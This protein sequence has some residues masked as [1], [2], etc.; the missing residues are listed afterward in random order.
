MPQGSNPGA[1]IQAAQ[2]LKTQ[3]VVPDQPKLQNA[4][5]K[6]CQ[7]VT[8][9][10]RQVPDGTPPELCAAAEGL[11]CFETD[12]ETLTSFRRLRLRWRSNP[13]N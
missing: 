11:E 10:P 7:R 5:A 3:R 6:V 1:V 8:A 4:Q 2:G 13:F 9:L 12:F